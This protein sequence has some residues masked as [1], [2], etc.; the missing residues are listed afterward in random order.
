MHRV[1][2]CGNGNCPIPIERT[3]ALF[4]SS[5]VR[6]RS[7]NSSGAS[8]GRPICQHLSD[9]DTEQDT[10]LAHDLRINVGRVDFKAGIAKIWWRPLLTK[11][12]RHARCELVCVHRR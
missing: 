6:A 10:R 8:H 2:L 5:P 1:R 7:L 4:A 9:A 3:T 12:E 11:L